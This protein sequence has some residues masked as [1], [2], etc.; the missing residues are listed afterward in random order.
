MLPYTIVFAIVWSILLTVFI[1]F[2][3]PVGP[4]ADLY[5]PE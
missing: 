2:G 1:V 4:G 5:L 3:F